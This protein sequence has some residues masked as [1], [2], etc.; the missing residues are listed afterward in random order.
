MNEREQK[1]F[2]KGK[3][4]AQLGRAISDNPYTHETTIQS[5]NHWAWKRGYQSIRPH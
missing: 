4:A 5:A 3:I 2:N 1:A